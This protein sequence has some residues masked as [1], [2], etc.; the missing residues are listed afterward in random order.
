MAELSIIVPVYNKSEH[1][2]TCISSLK[3]QSVKDAEYIFVDDCSTDGSL[4]IVRDCI[5]NDPRFILIEHQR[6]MGPHKARYDGVVAA[7]GEYIMFMDADDDMESNACECLIEKIKMKNSD[8]MQFGVTLVSTDDIDEVKLRSYELSINSFGE[9][10]TN[11]F[12]SFLEG[13]YFWALWNKIYKS[14]V[15]KKAF[16]ELGPLEMWLT[17]DYLE[18]I[19]ITYYASTYSFI[20]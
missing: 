10:R 11:A 14:D 18:T 2:E 8:I 5:V 6:N 13:K 12:E 15:V 9:E 16:N 7:T 3:K 4:Q 17:E 19:Y 20:D 1:I